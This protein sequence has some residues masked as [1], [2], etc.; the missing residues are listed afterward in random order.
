M[1]VDGGVASGSCEVLALPV[2]N[3]LAVPLNVAFCKAKIKKED[4]IGRFIVPDAEVIRFD[5]TVDE[6]TIVHVLDSGD[7]LVDQHQHSF[8]GEFPEGL[9]EEGLQ[10]WTHQIHH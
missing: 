4:F 3:M 10:G 2:G 1:G 6:V 9:V 5:V 7:H 8:Q